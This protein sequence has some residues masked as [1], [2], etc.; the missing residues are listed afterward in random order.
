MR[1]RLLPVLLLLS[2][3]ALLCAAASAQSEPQ[4]AKPSEPAGA[5]ASPQSGSSSV[6][7][8]GQAK[9][10]AKPEAGQRTKHEAKEEDEEA[11]FKQSDSVKWLAKITGLSPGAAYWASVVLNFVIVGVLLVVFL[12]SPMATFFRERTVG[13]RKSLEEARQSSAEAS[14]RLAEI[15]ARLAKLDAETAEMRAVA[16]REAGKEEKAARVAA[17]EAK[18]KIVQ[19]AEQEIAAAARLARGEL[20]SYAAELAVSLAE[21]KIQITAVTDRALVKEFVDHLGKEGK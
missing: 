21:K 17:E 14:R 16:D 3:L 18:V 1:L 7:N 19:G 6:E 20:K 13:I 9:P 5:A 8:K 11:Q 10:E 4:Q 2:F 15:E 12:K